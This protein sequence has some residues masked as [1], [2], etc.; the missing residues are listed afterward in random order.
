M[1]DEDRALGHDMIR[2]SESAVFNSPGFVL[3]N[4]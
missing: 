4:L 3:L 1:G 2:R